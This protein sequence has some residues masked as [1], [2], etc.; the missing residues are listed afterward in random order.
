[1]PRHCMGLHLPQ[2]GNLWVALKIGT[3]R[4]YVPAE[5]FVPPLQGVKIK[6][7]KRYCKKVALLP[8]R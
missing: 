5:R 8:G 2:R 7:L 6:W 4:C 1:M 3:M